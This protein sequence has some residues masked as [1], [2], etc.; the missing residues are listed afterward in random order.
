VKIAAAG[1]V[2][3]VPVMNGV[4]GKSLSGTINISDAGVAWVSVSISGAPLGM[5]FSMS[6]PAITASWARPVTGSYSLQVL[7]IDSAG[8]SA[9]A[10]VPISV[11]AK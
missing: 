4:A 10:V 7:V 8:L 2:I 5:S 9:K 6:G 3:T 1:P 11:L